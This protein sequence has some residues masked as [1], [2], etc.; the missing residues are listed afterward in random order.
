MRCVLLPTGARLSVRPTQIGVTRLRSFDG[1]GLLVQIMVVY[2]LTG[3]KKTSTEWFDG[4]GLW[5]ALNQE[6]VTAMGSWLRSQTTLLGV[7]SRAIRWTEVF[8]PLLVLSPWRNVAARTMAVALFWH[9]TWRRAAGLEHAVDLETAQRGFRWSL[10]LRNVV[11]RGL[12]EPA[13]QEAY[14]PLLGYLCREWNTHS[15]R[16]HR[17]ARGDRR[18]RLPPIASAIL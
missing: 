9:F 13:F 1:A 16:E 5:Y 4:T 12:A 15:S 8:G 2:V 17:S 10:Y 3:L 18:P 14:P 11:P 7:F 6:H